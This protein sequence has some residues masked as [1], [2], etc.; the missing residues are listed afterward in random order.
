MKRQIVSLALVAAFLG[1]LMLGT[2]S[3]SAQV[4]VP[5][6]SGARGLVNTMVGLVG[7]FI[8]LTDNEVQVGNVVLDHSLN[9]LQALN[10]V[11]KTSPTLHDNGIDVVDTVAI[12]TINECAL[13]DA[14]I[15]ILQGVLT[16]VQLE[17]LVNGFLGFYDHHGCPD[18]TNVVV[19]VLSSG[20]LVL[21]SH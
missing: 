1:T 14:Q 13:T 4:S 12:G 9:N 18:L 2:G 11:L 15:G 16:D 21:I 20:D 7:S 8:R 3:A 19:A 17:R 10:K 6:G 5:G